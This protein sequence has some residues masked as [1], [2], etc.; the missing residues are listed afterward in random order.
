MIIGVRNLN[1]I[2]IL[3]ARNLGLS[4]LQII[5]K[6]TIPGALPNIITGMR[7]GFGAIWRSVIASEMLVGGAGGLGNFMIN[8]QFS[9]SFDKIFVSIFVIAFIGL[10]VE[11]LL[12]KRIEKA[13]LE[14]WGILADRQI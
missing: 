14:K 11:I 3:T 12:F 8:S 9:F 7:L 6:V 1:P 10:F 4:K 5:F 2:W 13:T